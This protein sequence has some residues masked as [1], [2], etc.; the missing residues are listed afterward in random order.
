M[1]FRLAPEPILPSSS[2]G[3]V[4]DPGGVNAASTRAARRVVDDG[5]AFSGLTAF[6]QCIGREDGF[7]L[8][9]VLWVI[10]GLAGAAAAIAW[11][12]QGASAATRNRLLLTRAAWAREACLE[13]VAAQYEEA[14]LGGP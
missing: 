11:F 14:G 10:V 6:R 12:T 5:G 7:A 13:L 3:P 8:L 4:A 9:A 1:P 2:S